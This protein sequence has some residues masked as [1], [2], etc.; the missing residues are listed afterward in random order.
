MHIGSYQHAIF[1]ALKNPLSS[2]LP[3]NIF[4]VQVIFFICPAETVSYTMK[5]NVFQHFLEGSSYQTSRSNF[6]LSNYV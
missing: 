3:V 2:S 4:A 5:T 6:D 1:K